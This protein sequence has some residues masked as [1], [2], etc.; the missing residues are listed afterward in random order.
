MAILVDDVG[1]FP[2][3]KEA[4]KKLAE[5]YRAAQRACAEGRDLTQDARLYEHFYKPVA[6]S[7]EHKINSGIDVVNYPQHYDMHA[8]FLDAVNEHAKEPYL[9][10]SKHAVIPELFV[11]EREAKKYYEA[12]GRKLRLKVCVTGALELYLKTEFGFYVYEEVLDSLAK[13]VNAFLKNSLLNTKYVETT[14][15]AIDEPS[16]GFADLL[17]VSRDSLIAALEKSI[18]GVK[19]RVQIHMHS[20][21]AVDI[22]LAAQGIEIIGAEFAATPQNIEMISKKQLEKYDKFLRA[23]ITRTNFDTLLGE[24]IGAGAQPTPEQLV[25]SEEIIRTRFEKIRG[26]FG[27]R[28]AFAGPDCGLGSWGSPRAAQLLLERTV[29]AIKSAL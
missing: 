29:S 14:A 6:A 27:E 21:K 28:I 5:V 16:L 9:I 26:I 24:Q 13:S 17:N 15:V 25:E 1:S 2:L 12:S 7:L 11:V 20:M 18:S 10:E 19:A 23:G 22:P 4:K 3:A 8:Q